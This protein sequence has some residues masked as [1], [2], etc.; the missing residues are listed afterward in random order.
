MAKQHRWF[1]LIVIILIGFILRMTVIGKSAYPINDGGLFYRMIIDLQQNN[2]HI[3]QFTTYN[4][5]NIPFA[6]PP[7]PFY[8]VGLI[9][10]W[11][12]IDLFT[13]FRF[14]PLAFNLLAI[15]LV[16]LLVRKL[17]DGNEEVAL[18]STAFWVMLPPSFEWLIMGG[19]VTRS[20][21]FTFSILACYLFLEYITTH[22]FR[23]LIG[24]ILAGGI[25]GLSH[26]EI[27]WVLCF[28][29]AL[30]WVFYAKTRKDILPPL[31]FYVGCAALMSPVYLFS[32][33][34]AWHSPHSLRDFLREILLDP[35]FKRYHLIQPDR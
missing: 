7:L 1:F 13:L 35:T 18:L 30:I 22:K 14:L 20:I 17:V 27:F 16:Y 25:T 31:Y 21:A 15:P 6:Y 11:L 12:K 2:Y 33:L 29:T 19:G 24:A 23:Y 3:P 9:N 8:V 26:L 10:T 28:T 4:Q 5:G 32:R 34:A